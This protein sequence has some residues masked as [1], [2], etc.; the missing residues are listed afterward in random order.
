MKKELS[1][2]FISLLITLVIGVG[3]LAVGLNSVT[4]KNA[5]PIKDSPVAA[6]SDPASS[7]AA[8]IAQLQDLVSQYQQREQQYQQELDTAQQQLN[9]DQQAMQQVQSLL[10]FLQNRGVISIDGSGRIRVP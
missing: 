1:A 9:Q 2:I 4:N 10:L 5:I 6:S 8:Q 3:M 7:P